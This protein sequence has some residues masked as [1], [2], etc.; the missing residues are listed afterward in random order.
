MGRPPKALR[1]T[2]PSAAPAPTALSETRPEAS[3]C[4]ALGAAPAAA[5]AAAPDTLAAVPGAPAAP[6]SPILPKPRP[7]PA[8]AP[9]AARGVVTRPRDTTPLPAISCCDVGVG[10]AVRAIEPSDICGGQE[11]KAVLGHP[12]QLRR[13]RLRMQVPRARTMVPIAGPLCAAESSFLGRVRASFAVRWGPW[14]CV[15]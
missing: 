15:A 8:A 10:V 1:A 3:C 11:A 12:N 4:E 6:A 9:V 7:A 5:F 13:E 2:S 14:V